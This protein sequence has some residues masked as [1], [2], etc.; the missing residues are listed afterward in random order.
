MMSKSSKVEV[1][2][3]DTKVD[4]ETKIGKEIGKD[5]S[6]EAEGSI[7]NSELNNLK[8]VCLSVFF[9]HLYYIRD[10]G[11]SYTYI[12]SLIETEIA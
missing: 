10:L 4:V 12:M 8:R 9:F 1:K 11:K 6:T 2:I 5:S 3:G 7:S